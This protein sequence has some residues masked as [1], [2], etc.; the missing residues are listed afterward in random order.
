MTAGFGDSIWPT[1]LQNFTWMI[2]TDH[3]VIPMLNDTN[4]VRLFADGP[5]IAIFTD[6]PAANDRVV[7]ISDLRRDDLRG[8][9]ADASKQLVLAEKKLRYGLLQGALEQEA[10]AELAML[11]SGDASGVDSTSQRIAGDRL[12]V[13][14]AVDASAD[15][16]GVEESAIRLRSALVAGNTVVASASGLEK[17][18]AWWE[19]V[20]DT[21]DT[22]STGELGLHWGTVQKGNGPRVQGGTGG[23]SYTKEKAEEIAKA[24][25]KAK[26]EAKMAEIIKANRENPGRA[27]PKNNNLGPNQ[28][29]GGGMEYA[30]LVVVATIE[31]IAFTILS[32]MLIERIYSETELLIDWLAAGGFREA[33]EP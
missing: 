33:I 5:R 10:L 22:R 26:H 27:M 29:G 15:R 16:L 25:R 8:L 4:G 18:G 3:V 7:G 28:G 31:S 19:I 1:A 11:E 32:Q 14:T 23:V 2:W 17:R 20:A 13:L 12:M 9:A 24:Q 21:G 30:I 6:A